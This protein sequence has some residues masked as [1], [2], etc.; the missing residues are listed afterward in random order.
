MIIS[1]LSY[2]LAHS[3]PV[4]RVVAPIRRSF[5]RFASTPYFVTS[6]LAAATFITGDWPCAVAQI[7]ADIATGFVSAFALMLGIAAYHKWSR[8]P[9]QS[10]WLLP[11]LAACGLVGALLTRLFAR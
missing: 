11:G 7:A 3:R 1:L 5:W 4:A 8:R 6:A 9:F 2:A 10:S